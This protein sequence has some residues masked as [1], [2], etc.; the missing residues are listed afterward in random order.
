MATVACYAV[1]WAPILCHFFSLR[2]LA[3]R[4]SISHFDQDASIL[5]RLRFP[6]IHRSS[7]LHECMLPLD[8]ANFLE[9]GSPLARERTYSDR[10]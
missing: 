1:S 7:I 9:S 4:S 3:H 8:D 6:P 5:H 2:V 10:K